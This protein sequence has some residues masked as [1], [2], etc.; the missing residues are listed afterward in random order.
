LLG[1]QD[2]TEST[3]GE[4]AVTAQARRGDLFDP[5]CP[6][7]HLLDRVG[8]KW[9]SMLVK[10]LAEAEGGEVRFGEL[11]RRAPGIS[12]KMLSQT[13]RHL[14]RDGLANRRVEETVPPRVHYSLTPLGRSLERTLATLRD[15][16]E[17]NMQEID[18]ARQD[19]DAR[20]ADAAKA[21]A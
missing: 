1:L 16:A 13:L 4:L 9:T 6:T 17:T 12:R 15:W 10:V 20:A 2:G 19:H 7:R 11:Q 21:A 5:A 14:E 8:D 18:D 3:P